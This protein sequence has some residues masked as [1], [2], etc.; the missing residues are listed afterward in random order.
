ME[1][2]WNY[3]RKKRE[4]DISFKKWILGPTYRVKNGTVTR[5]N[6]IEKEG[7]K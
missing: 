6:K 4:I 3:H 1:T 2:L 7:I 5:D